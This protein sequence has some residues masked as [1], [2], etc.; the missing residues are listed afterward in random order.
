M[1]VCCRA[2]WE[3]G[4]PRLCVGQGKRM[5]S[6]G[7]VLEQDSMGLSR[8][9][10]MFLA[11]LGRTEEGSGARDSSFGKWCALRKSFKMLNIFKTFYFCQLNDSVN[12]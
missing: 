7:L 1:D 12:K 5:G 3:A 2:S 11:E 9:N 4:Q 6:R 10:K 8:G